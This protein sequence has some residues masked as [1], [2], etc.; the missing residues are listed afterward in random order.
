MRWLE[1]QVA[2]IREAATKTLQKIAQVRHT[3]VLGWWVVVLKLTVSVLGADGMEAVVQ[4]ACAARQHMP[5]LFYLCTRQL[6]LGGSSCWR[7]PG[8][9]GQHLWIES[10][11]ISPCNL[12]RHCAMHGYDHAPLRCCPSVFL[13][14]FGPEWAKEHLV[15]QVLGM[16]KNPHYLYRMTVL[17]AI[18][19]LANY[20]SQ[21]VFVSTMLPVLV[22]CAKDRVP[23]VKFNVAKVRGHTEVPCGA[24]R[25]MPC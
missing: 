7:A 12:L 16:V 10:W 17:V 14:E 1:D 6:R 25:L 22:Q 24:L 15:P 4:G 13:Q 23:N 11:C 9:S 20:V 19:S 3:P 8:V 18:S 5:E 21:E 2:S